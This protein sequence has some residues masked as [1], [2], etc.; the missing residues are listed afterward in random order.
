MSG[1]GS[2]RRPSSVPPQTFAERWAQTFGP[3]TETAPLPKKEGG[4]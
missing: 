3:K 2:G 4:A 1:K